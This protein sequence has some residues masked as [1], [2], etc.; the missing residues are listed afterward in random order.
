VTE[1]AGVDAE[2]VW[3]TRDG[4]NA[5]DPAS[6]ATTVVWQMPTSLPS[7]SRCDANCQCAVMGCGTFFSRPWA[8]GERKRAGERRIR[9]DPPAALTTKRNDPM[10][11]E[12]KCRTHVLFL[13]SPPLAH[14]ANRSRASPSILSCGQRGSSPFVSRESR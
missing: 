7:W 8:T 13:T 4:G 1:R 5:V 10:R 12:G 9:P 11:R 2:G 3:A 6:L 14:G